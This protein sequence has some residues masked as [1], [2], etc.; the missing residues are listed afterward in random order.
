MKI[1]DKIKLFAPDEKIEVSNFTTMSKKCHWKCLNCGNEFEAIP[2]TIFHRHSK[3]ICLKC[4]PPLRQKE[5]QNREEIYNMA[6]KN[7]SIKLID[8]YVNQKLRVK[9]QC[10]D[11]GQINDF[12]WLDRKN[13]D[14]NYCKGTRHNCNKQSYQYLLNK[15]YDDRFI[16]ENFTSMN[17]KVL[18]KCRCG[19]CFTILPISTLRARGIKCPKCERNRSKAEIY[20]EDYLVKHQ[21]FFEREKHFN[22]MEYKTR[23]DFYIPE[24]NL[25]I[26]FH[27]EQ[28][29]SFTSYFYSSQEEW[30]LAKRRDE[31]KEKLA[32]ENNINY[33]VIPYNFQNNLKEILDNLFGSTTISQESRAKR[34]EIQNFLNK[35][36]D[37]V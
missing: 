25:I 16:V 6:Q 8:I 17:D 26:E 13:L 36:E 31:V 21:I 32:I 23:Y 35:E 37:I 9:F 20:I 10:L 34:L 3:S 11:C 18:L 1:E 30:E 22:W 15:K 4:N 14:C 28:H 12:R 29:Y 5:K 33:L 7:K 2:D 19:F 24:S 27:G